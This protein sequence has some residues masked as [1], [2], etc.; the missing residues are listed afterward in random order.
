M[1]PAGS[2]T[3]A[4]AA[5]W[6]AEGSDRVELGADAPTAMPRSR[7]VGKAAARCR[8]SL[9][10]EAQPVVLYEGH[11]YRVVDMRTDRKY[12]RY[13]GIEGRLLMV[14]ELG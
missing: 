4:G 10:R 6:R 8:W 11:G 5:W 13:T 9:R 1:T 14:K 7:P 3:A 2:A 12:E